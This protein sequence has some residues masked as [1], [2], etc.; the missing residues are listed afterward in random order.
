MENLYRRPTRLGRTSGGKPSPCSGPISLNVS[1]V[2][3]LDRVGNDEQAQL[4]YLE[5][6][7]S[8]MRSVESDLV[9]PSPLN[10]VEEVVPVVVR[11]QLVVIATAPNALLNLQRFHPHWM[12]VH[13]SIAWLQSTEEISDYQ[14]V[15][16]RQEAWLR[17]RYP[18]DVATAATTTT[19]AT[20][21]LA[22]RGCG[23]SSITAVA[24]H[25]MTLLEQQRR[26]PT[27]SSSRYSVA[28][29]S[30]DAGHSKVSLP[31]LVFANPPPPLPVNPSIT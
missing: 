7:L 4:L 5:S 30:T 27:W 31:Y 13:H 18:D 28:F 24:R 19:E 9:L 21:N 1:V 2:V 11:L 15:A 16:A 26:D 14:V 29:E 22:N 23:P 10:G 3:S 12:K 20:L 25:L 8:R 17:Q 6:A